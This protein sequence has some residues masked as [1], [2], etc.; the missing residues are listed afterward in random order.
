[1]KEAI[2]QRARELGFDD[3][4]FA[5]ATPPDH[6]AE[7]KRWLAAERH[8][9]MAYL[10]R[11]AAKRVDPDLVLA[12]AKTIITLAASYATLDECRGARSVG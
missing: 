12:G 8:G 10:E 5:R 4:R 2:R 1:M 9:A 6:G 7:F 3:C 11:N